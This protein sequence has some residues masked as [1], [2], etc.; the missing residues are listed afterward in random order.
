MITRG[1]QK[2]TLNATRSFP[3]AAAASQIIIMGFLSAAT[4][5]EIGYANAGRA[6][7]AAALKGSSRHHH[8]RLNEGRVLS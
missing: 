5:I 4:P 6:A 1:Y 7:A 8:H 3:A 2:G